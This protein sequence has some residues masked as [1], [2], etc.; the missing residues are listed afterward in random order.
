MTN[1][2]WNHKAVTWPFGLMVCRVAQD[3]IVMSELADGEDP[4]TIVSSPVD[5]EPWPPNQELGDSSLCSVR[6]PLSKLARNWQWHVV[7][8][9]FRQDTRHGIFSSPVSL[10]DPG[11][12]ISI[13]GMTRE[14]REIQTTNYTFSLLMMS[15]LNNFFLYLVW[16]CPGSRA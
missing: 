13:R 4:V 8:T 12:S 6:A 1:N 3:G 9:R 11:L 10:P 5:R 16:T 7:F 2:R 14:P 15:S